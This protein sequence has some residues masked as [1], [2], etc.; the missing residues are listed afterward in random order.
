MEVGRQQGAS[1]IRPNYGRHQFVPQVVTETMMG[2][3]EINRALKRV[4]RSLPIKNSDAGEKT[5]QIQCAL[6]N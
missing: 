5:L 4:K 2:D 6:N 1:Q 3:Q